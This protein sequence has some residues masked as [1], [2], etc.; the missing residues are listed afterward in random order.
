[1]IGSLIKK[2]FGSH[3]ERTMKKMWP[4]VDQINEWFDKFDSLPDEVIQ[5][6]VDEFR[7]RLQ[8][9]EKLDDLL[10]EA[11]AVVK[12]ACRRHV[13][14]SWTAA[15]MPINWVEVPYDVQLIGGVVLNQ[16]KIAE[17][18]TGEGKTLVA[19]QALYL[20]A[21]EGRGCHLA[22]FGDFL[23]LRDSEW[24]GHILKW[25]GITIGC[26]K[27]EM[28]PVV[29]REQ[30]ACDVTYGQSS[31]FGFDYLRDNMAGSSADLVQGA[32]S[33]ISQ[34]LVDEIIAAAKAGD[35]TANVVVADQFDV[36]IVEVPQER[37]GGL[38]TEFSGRFS[39]SQI[40]VSWPGEEAGVRLPDMPPRAPELE[41]DFNVAIIPAG[42][43]RIR[44]QFVSRDHHYVIVDEADSMLIDEAR[45]PLI[46][47]GQVDR[48][49]HRFVQMK[50]LVE[51]LSHKQSLLINR[52]LSEAD[53][54]LAQ[55]DPDSRYRGGIRLLQV[56]KGAPKN[57]RLLKYMNEPE[58]ARLINKCENDFIIDSKSKIVEKGMSYVEEELFYVIDEKGHGVD[59]SE[60]GREELS[61]D[62]PNRFLLPDLV[63]EF[64]RIEDDPSLTPVEREQKKTEMRQATD[65]KSEEL[66]NISQ[67]LRAY[68]LY[69]KDVEYV[70]QD[71]KVII[72]D[73][74]TGRLQPGRRYSEGLHQAI[75]AKEGVQIEKETQTLATIT[76]QN[77]FRM[78]DKM[79]GMTGT[80]ET[81]ASEFAHTYKMDVVVIPTNKPLA[82][83]DFDDVI[84]RTR[85]EKYNA[86]I[87]EIARLN[88]DGLPVLVGTVSVEVSELLSRMLK[89]TGISHSVLNAKYHQKE[90]EI[91]A[92]AGQAAAVTIA[93]NMAGRGT[94]IK[95]GPGVIKCKAGESHDGKYCPA[96]PYKPNGAPVTKDMQPCGLQI[97]GT[98]R[99]EARRIDRQLRG[100][101]GRQGDPG[102]SRFFL[103]LE[104][105]L[106]R[107]FGSE[108]ISSILSRLGLQEG[109]EIQ[110]P[111]ITR[112]ITRAQRRIEE[113][114]FERRKRT[115]DYDNVMNKQRETI[116]GLRR[117]VLVS[118]DLRTIVL[119]ICFDAIGVLIENFKIEQKEFVDSK[120]YDLD[121]FEAYIATMVPSVN[122]EGLERPLEPDEN[123]LTALVERI[124]KVYDTAREVLGSSYTLDLSRHVILQ[125]ID[126]E[127]R[128][129]LLGIDELREG[130]HMVSYQQLDPLT[131]YQKQ[132]TY[133]FQD[134]VKTVQRLVFEHFFRW[135]S[136][137]EERQRTANIDYGRGAEA[138][139][140]GGDG[141][142][143][144]PEGTPVPESA[145]ARPRTFHRDQPKVGRNDPC[146]CGSGKKYK[147][148]CG[149]NAD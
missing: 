8:D 54:L 51:S 24:A 126:I 2:M 118:E 137:F 109:E 149:I 37:I 69:E 121:A 117:E 29:R 41:Q 11:F 40:R 125:A 145:Q 61:P 93:T 57:K 78:Y 62:D 132:A 46:I 72:V 22:T 99:H 68:S 87:E 88:K 63:E 59:L 52:F 143:E 86:I 35:E 97:I 139:V 113:I 38:L 76:I 33:K 15:D 140:A 28:D 114:N 81:E 115:L 55:N 64:S 127:W 56:K 17:M 1:M 66:Q 36:L 94:D 27:Q 111:F 98:E 58:I 21:L 6:K 119:D 124:A 53:E 130:I 12:T 136:A 85:R 26:I 108:R 45:T 50:P 89:R 13:G 104:D 71:N 144:V 133:M 39:L 74:F 75:E 25:L 16:G 20:N 7:A 73:E 48:S 9:G 77:Y 134:M 90:S 106:M 83:D 79:S 112:A 123:Y 148:C 82:R 92:Q 102:S 84:Y 95:L 101:A 43:A 23:A 91:V 141:V 147:K 135:S 18:A 146:P 103:S 116:Y 30:Y 131:E 128:D 31:E 138:P 42:M 34:V 110:H 14:Q 105:D 60:Q 19:I 120:P 96:C 49:T 4:V 129:H 67:L 47:S 100:R 142:G 5:G 107:L 3:A 80:A 65:Q 10:P 44:W 122:L 70:V 32:R